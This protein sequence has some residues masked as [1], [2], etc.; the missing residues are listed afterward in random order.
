MKGFIL[1]GVAALFA[2]AGVFAGDAGQAKAVV[3]DDC[4]DC[5]PA[6]RSGLIS[7]IAAR[8]QARVS[9]RHAV[10]A[11]TKVVTEQ[12]AVIRTEA[13]YQTKKVGEKVTVFPVES[14]K[15]SK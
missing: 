5:Q 11:T 15:K 7:G 1:S 14:G 10:P 6:G 4:C 2:A 13:I 12:P 8:R 3:K 9:A